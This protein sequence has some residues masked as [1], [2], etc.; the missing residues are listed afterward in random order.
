[1]AAVRDHFQKLIV[2][3]Q[4]QAAPFGAE[5]SDTESSWLQRVDLSTRRHHTYGALTIRGLSNQQ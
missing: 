4:K 2:G 3:P 5:E 1:L